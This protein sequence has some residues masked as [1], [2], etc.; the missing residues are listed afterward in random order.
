V[1]P[2]PFPADFRGRGGSRREPGVCVKPATKWPVN[3]VG[4]DDLTQPAVCADDVNLEHATQ[5]GLVQD[6]H[7]VEALSAQDPNEVFQVRILPRGPRRRLNFVD[8]QGA[9]AVREHDRVEPIAIAQ[10]VARCGVELTQR[11][12]SPSA[13]SRQTS[14][15][16]RLDAR[17]ARR[18]PA[19]TRTPTRFE[20]ARHS[21]QVPCSAGSVNAGPLDVSL[22]LSVSGG[23][24][25]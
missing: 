10:Q 5:V 11:S 4:A 22:W 16:R 25:Q 23:P 7:M 14:G 19:W 12:S 3:R 18:V 24:R 20:A 15:C 17:W 13:S 1:G 6:D 2:T 9:H 8:S 21:R